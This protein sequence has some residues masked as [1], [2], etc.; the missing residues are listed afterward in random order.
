MVWVAG[1]GTAQRKMSERMSAGVRQVKARGHRL[2]GVP[3]GTRH[4]HGLV[5]VLLVIF[6][7]AIA[8]EG[9]EEV[10]MVYLLLLMLVGIHDGSDLV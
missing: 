9:D 10:F 4:G 8:V 6:Q 5:I 1:P 7:P 3:R 2:H